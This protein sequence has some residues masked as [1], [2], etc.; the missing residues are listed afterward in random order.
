[1]KKTWHEQT[2][3]GQ[4]YQ[5]LDY[6]QR[7]ERISEYKQSQSRGFTSFDSLPDGVQKDLKEKELDRI[8]NLRE[9]KDSLGK[10]LERLDSPEVS[11]DDAYQSKG[12]DKFEVKNPLTFSK[13]DLDLL[14][15]K[16][17]QERITPIVLSNAPVKEETKTPQQHVD[18]AAIVVQQEVTEKQVEDS[19]RNRY[20]STSSI[21]DYRKDP[22]SFL[23]KKEKQAESKGKELSKWEKQRLE[24]LAKQADI[25]SDVKENISYAGNVSQVDSQKTTVKVKDLIVKFTGK[26]RTH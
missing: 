6:Q 20:A 3:S 14:R 19:R 18:G 24:K 26:D 21:P 2:L 5:K 8:E 13:D 11:F 9:Q 25:T 22:F 12:S 17:K 23:P 4:D 16:A 15:A 1:M 10:P 7:E